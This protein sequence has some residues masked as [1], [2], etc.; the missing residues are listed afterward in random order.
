MKRVTSGVGHAFGSESFGS[1][2][3]ILGLGIFCRILACGAIGGISLLGVCILRKAV[4]AR[5]ADCG[6]I[7]PPLRWIAIG[8]EAFGLCVTEPADSAVESIATSRPLRGGSGRGGTRAGQSP[9]GRCQLAV[10]FTSRD[11]PEHGRQLLHAFRGQTSWRGTARRMNSRGAGAEQRPRIPGAEKSRNKFV[12]TT[13]VGSRSWGGA[14]ESRMGFEDSG[15]SA[16]ARPRASTTV[17]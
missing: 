14:G 9:L 11:S 16:P 17:N 12:G 15:T 2:C 8:S 1:D 3:S 10:Q 7:W 5:D 6:E 13:T 4:L